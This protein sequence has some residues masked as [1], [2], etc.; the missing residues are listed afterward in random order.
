MRRVFIAAVLYALMAPVVANAQQETAT[1]I[2]TVIDA[3]KAALPGVTVTVR[4]VETG[5]NRAGVTAPRDAIALPRFRR[6][7]T[8]S[9]RRCRDSAPASAAVSR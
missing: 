6:D 8:R 9:P 4:N 7:R 5:F 2:G 3:Q 1:V